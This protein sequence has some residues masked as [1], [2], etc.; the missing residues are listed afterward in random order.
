MSLLVNVILVA[1]L[2]RDKV[3]Y[4]VFEFR[5]LMSSNLFV[6]ISSTLLFAK[7]FQSVTRLLK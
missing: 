4:I 3:F 5:T 6:E 2:C 7:F 1:M